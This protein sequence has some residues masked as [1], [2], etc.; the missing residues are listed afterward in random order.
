MKRR[1]D[2]PVIE[3]PVAPPPIEHRDKKGRRQDPPDGSP[4]TVSYY[5]DGSI[6]CESHWH[7]GQLRDSADGKPAVAYYRPD[8]TLRHATHYRLSAA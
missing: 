6:R 8:G 3:R 5:P 4:A 7:V 1:T 2:T